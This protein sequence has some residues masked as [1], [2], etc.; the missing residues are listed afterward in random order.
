[1]SSTVAA[2]FAEESVMDRLDSTLGVPLVHQDRHLDLAGRNHVDIDTGGKQGLKHLAGH[3][4]G[5]R[6][7][8]THD[9]DLG[10]LVIE[11]HRLAADDLLIFLQTI[12]TNWDC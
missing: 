8:R 4:G 7:T 11:L 1:M 5:I 9:G 2:K 6:H 12:A 3:T 10:D